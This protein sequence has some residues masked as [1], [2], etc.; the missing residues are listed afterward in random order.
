MLGCGRCV[1]ECVI[2]RMCGKCGNMG[3]LDVCVGGVDAW[4][5]LMCGWVRGVNVWYVWIC[6]RC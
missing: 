6:G 1:C 4:E 5:V 2:V 3:C